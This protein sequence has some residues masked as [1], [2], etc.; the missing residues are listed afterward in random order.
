MSDLGQFMASHPKKILRC[1]DMAIG[2][3]QQTILEVASEEDPVLFQTLTKKEK[4]RV[5]IKNLPVNEDPI[6][7]CLP[8]AC[9]VN[10]FMCVQGTVVRTGQPK[11]LEV[12][13]KL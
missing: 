13:C 1:F 10:R 8:R 7:G 11:M 3:A 12:C 4:Y 2:R 9:D 5:R 6:K